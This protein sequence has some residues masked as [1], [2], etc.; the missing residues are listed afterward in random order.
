[1]P[2]S[3]RSPSVT[4]HIPDLMSIRHILAAWSLKLKCQLEFEGAN[5]D[6]S[7]TEADAGTLLDYAL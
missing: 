7:V 3:Q 5:M 2:W 1:L 6:L 4:D